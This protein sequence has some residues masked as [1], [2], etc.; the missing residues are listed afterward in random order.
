MYSIRISVNERKHHRYLRSF[1]LNPSN[2]GVATQVLLSVSNLIP[3]LLPLPAFSMPSRSI[4]RSKKR[5]RSA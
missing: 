1:C 4:H 5:V 2:L 3:S